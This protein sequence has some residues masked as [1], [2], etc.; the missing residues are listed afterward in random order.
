VSNVKR[1]RITYA[2]GILLVILLGLASRSQLQL[3]SLVKEYAGDLLW[4]LAVYL[5][6][7]FLFSQLSIIRV[8][9]TAALISLGVEVSQL[10]HAAWMDHIRGL[11]VGGLLLGH[12]FLWSDLV[13]YGIGIII[14]IFMDWW[15]AQHFF[16]RFYK[17]WIMKK[18]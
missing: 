16:L 7:A 14:G 2:V 18:N 10:Y 8:A 11:R 6:V 4:A 13:C 1:N 17:A 12:G 3:P 15:M 5:T 9:V